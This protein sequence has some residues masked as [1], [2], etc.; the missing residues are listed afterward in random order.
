MVAER[1]LAAT[2]AVLAR[3]YCWSVRRIALLLIVAGALAACGASGASSSVAASSGS[4][5]RTLAR[6]GP[7]GARTLARGSLTRVYVQSG[8]VYACLTGSRR[9]LTLGTTG[10][11][12]RA[13]HVD[14]VAVAG[15]L[16]AAGLLNCGVD[17]GA[18]AIEVRRVPDGHQLL[19]T[20]AITNPGP[21]SY[22]H[23]TGLVLTPAGAAAWIARARSIVS[24][25]STTE[26]QAARA[27][28]TRRLD[29]GAGIATGSL[30]L[31]GHTV[32][33][34]DGPSTRSARL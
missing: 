24:H 31:T 13:S 6:C 3:Q 12:I 33:W 15:R 2:S 11:C 10:S 9:R 26:V 8:T 30:R 22:A 5:P 21:E 20:P 34:R 23:V 17:T 19:T 28:S 25:R 27:G 14:A 16:V 7:A 4:S 32:T 29:S 18:A 1:Y